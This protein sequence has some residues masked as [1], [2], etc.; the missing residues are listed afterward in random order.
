MAISSPP[1]VTARKLTPRETTA[2]VS[3]GPVRGGFIAGNDGAVVGATGETPSDVVV[4]AAA[5]VASMME[6]VAPADVRA[7]ED[8]SSC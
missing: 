2:D 6:A 5:G 7:T 3:R 1:T 4:V 8:G